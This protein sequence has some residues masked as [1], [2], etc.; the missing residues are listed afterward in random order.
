MVVLLIIH[1]KKKIIDVNSNV[2]GDN[3]PLFTM[4]EYNEIYYY[5]WNY[6]KLN[7]LIDN[8]LEYTYKLPKPAYFVYLE[9]YDD[10]MDYEG[11]FN[12]YSSDSKEYVD[13]VIFTVIDLK[14]IKE[15][16]RYVGTA[17]LYM[18]Y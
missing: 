3:E 16:L 8:N 14:Y 2:E 13:E 5:N 7:Y 6:D 10:S 11:F 17:I 1:Q 9:F 15:E 12:L 4:T 18:Y